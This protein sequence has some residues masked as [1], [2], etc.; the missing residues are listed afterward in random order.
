VQVLYACFERDTHHLGHLT[1]LRQIGIIMDY[2]T[3]FEQLAIHIEGLSDSFFK[4][5]FINGLKEVIQ[6]HI[7]MQCTTNMVGSL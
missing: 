3:T 4:E 6:A 5:C 1:K 7:M 2:I